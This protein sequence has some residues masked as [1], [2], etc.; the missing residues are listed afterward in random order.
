[1]P[2]FDDSIYPGL[3]ASNSFGEFFEAHAKVVNSIRKYSLKRS[4]SLIGGMMTFPEFQASTLR[5]EVLQHFVVASATGILGPWRCSVRAWL[6]KLGDGYVGRL[7][8]P[9]E[10]VFVSRVSYEG[11]DYLVFEGLYEGS[12]F[13]L[14]RFC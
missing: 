6:N 7:E 3:S 14:Q 5:L 1:M 10:D 12:N 9:A 8:D 13:Y 11:A 4:V 2:E